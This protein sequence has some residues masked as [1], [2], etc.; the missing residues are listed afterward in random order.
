MY[1]TEDLKLRF[2]EA[3]IA[4]DTW[5]LKTQSYLCGPSTMGK[6]VCFARGWKLWI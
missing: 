5:D 1:S 4:V 3:T 2:L 6:G